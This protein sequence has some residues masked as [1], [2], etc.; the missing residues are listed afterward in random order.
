MFNNRFFFTT[1]G[2]VHPRYKAILDRATALGYTLPSPAVQYVHNTYMLKLI[3][4]GTINELDA[5]W[6][7]ANDG[8]KEFA[9]LNWIDPLVKQNTL[10]NSPTWISNVGFEGNGTNAYINSGFA[11]ATQGVSYTLNSAS[12]GVY[13]KNTT[14][15]GAGI[16]NVLT[17]STQGGNHI[18]LGRNGNNNSR[19]SIRLND[20]L[21][22]ILFAVQSQYLADTLYS[23]NRNSSTNLANYM[24]GVLVDSGLKTTT[25]IP[26][27]NVY[28][29]ARNSSGSPAFFVQSGIQISMVFYGSGNVDHSFMYDS[30]NSLMLN[31]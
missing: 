26:T 13:V 6:F 24:N 31:I 5:L 7:Y 8:S 15:L 27:G 20:D 9:T 11:P 28:I 14:T 1:I 4:S 19:L 3:S 21:T 30:F 25:A 29:L 22:D 12:T 18:F 16:T 2:G 17:G 23:G 10:V